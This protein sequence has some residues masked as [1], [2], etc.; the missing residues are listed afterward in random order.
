LLGHIRSCRPSS[1]GCQIRVT[2]TP[3]D[4]EPPPAG[5][6]VRRARRP[7]GWVSPGP[8]PTGDPSA[9]LPGP[10]EDLCYLAGDWRI[11]QR[12]D[13]HRWSLDDLVTAWIAAREVAPLP[14]RRFADLGSGIGSVLM[15]LAWRF[16]EASGVGIEAQPL[17]VDLARRSLAWNGIV[18]RCEVRLGDLRNPGTLPASAFDLVTGTPPYLPPGSATESQRV[19]R[20]AC[21]VEHRGGIEAYCTA[22]ARLLAPGGTF[23]ACESAAQVDRFFR[24][25]DAAGLAVVRRLDVV[26]R[27]GKPPLFSVC[28]MRLLADATPPIAD[29][30]LVVRDRTGQ[31]TGAFRTVRRDM[32]MPP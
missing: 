21:A 25:A 26:P 29:P 22:A 32:G 16:P 20:A 12:R 9:T 3:T 8:P 7:V 1:D 4:D 17:S 13:G 24:A 2:T 10:D 15:L 6:I 14:P 28:A 19:Q 30:L 5:G 11:F 31:R 18:H 23:V 27:E